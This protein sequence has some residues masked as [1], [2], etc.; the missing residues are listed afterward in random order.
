M[1]SDYIP[2]SIALFVIAFAA[3]RVLAAFQPGSRSVAQWIVRGIYHAARWL[4]S[5]AIA[6]DYGLQRFHEHKAS[7]PISPVNEDL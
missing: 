7:L 1:L 4:W 3:W 6:C 5:A 2:G